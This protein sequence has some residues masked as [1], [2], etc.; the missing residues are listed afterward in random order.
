MPLRTYD[1][2]ISHAWKY[3][4]DYDRLIG[5]L[6]NAP[7]FRFRNYSAP[8]EK[9]LL[10]LDSTNVHTIQQIKESIKRKIRPVNCVIIISGMYY[11]NRRWMQYELD[12]ARQMGK[13][14]I[15][16]YPWG[17]NRM[18]FEISSV[19]TCKVNWNTSSIV[20]AI[21]NYSL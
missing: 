3:G 10:N 9:P 4:A 19:A 16:V 21:R 6:N 1:L 13:P 2:F 7:Y 20:D 8:Q 18:P 14:I 12:V 15:A 5:L 11:N 17:N